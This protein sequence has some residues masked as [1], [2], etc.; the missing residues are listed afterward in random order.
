MAIVDANHVAENV[1]TLKKL[2]EYLCSA[3]VPQ[4]GPVRVTVCEKCES[5]CAYG[6]QY[7]KLYRAEKAKKE[8]APVKT[9]VDQ[10]TYTEQLKDAIDQRMQAEKCAAELL[11]KCKELEQACKASE[12]KAEDAILRAAES[13]RNAAGMLERCRRAAELEEVVEQLNEQCKV[14]RKRIEDAMVRQEKAEAETEHYRNKLIRFKAKI[15]DLE[16]PEEN[17]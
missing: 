1:K 5:Q 4:S 6:R 12:K 16:H 9:P 3:A 11:G 10:K 2:R 8:E 7:L 13:E 15:Y 17:D 14:M